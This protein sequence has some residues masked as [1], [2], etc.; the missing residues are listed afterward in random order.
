MTSSH[1]NIGSLALD[2]VMEYWERAMDASEPFDR[3]RWQSQEVTD[4][5]RVTVELRHQTF[6]MTVGADVDAWAKRTGANLPWA[7]DHFLE[8]ISGWPLNPPPSSEWWPYK[9]A[10]HEGHVDASAKFSHTYPERFW[11]KFA[12]KKMGNGPVYNRGI[13]YP[14]GDLNDVVK[15]LE[16]EPD[17]RQAYLPVWFPEDTGAIQGQRVPCTLGYHFLST[18]DGKLDITYHIR[19]CDLLRHFQDDVYMA[20]R[21]LQWVCERFVAPAWEPGELRMN[22]G[23]LHRFV[24]DAANR[25]ARSD[26]RSHRESVRIAEALS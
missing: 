7:E 1:H 8:R 2:N 17:T 10:G 26:A 11:P 22:I 24:G 5:D 21:L 14:Y 18:P 9:V 16:R 23:S 15:L 25:K 4:P 20:G 6:Q 19:S 3:G 13:R 12:E